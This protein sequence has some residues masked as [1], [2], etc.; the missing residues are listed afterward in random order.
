MDQ[1][2][3]FAWRNEKATTISPVCGN[4]AWPLRITVIGPHTAAPVEPP[5]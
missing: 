3:R 2:K 5:P 1:V 4:Y